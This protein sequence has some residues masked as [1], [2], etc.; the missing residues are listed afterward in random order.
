MNNED[1]LASMRQMAW[2]RAKAE[3]RGMS[4]VKYYTNEEEHK[5]SMKFFKLV[6][7][8]IE[9]VEYEGLHE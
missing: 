2:E 5:R 7:E 1:I 3:L 6:K 9:K 8:F 4:C